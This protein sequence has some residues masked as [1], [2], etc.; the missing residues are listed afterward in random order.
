[1]SNKLSYQG[2]LP[3]RCYTLA[4]PMRYYQW[5]EHGKKQDLKLQCVREP[6]CLLP[7]TWSTTFPD[8]VFYQ[9]LSV[10]QDVLNVGNHVGWTM[11]TQRG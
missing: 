7:P 8:V 5:G 1:M 9:D 3:M 10:Q 6:D 4:G 11:P 2:V